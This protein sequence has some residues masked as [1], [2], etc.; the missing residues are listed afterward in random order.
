MEQALVCQAAC[1]SG[2]ECTEGELVRD[3]Q[4]QLDRVRFILWDL[5]YYALG[6]FAK[7]VFKLT[8]GKALQ[9]AVEGI[10]CAEQQG[11]FNSALERAAARVPAQRGA[12]NPLE[13]KAKKRKLDV[14]GGVK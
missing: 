1:N 14:G 10:T 6:T 11:R 4:L 2:G 8:G 3:T 9:Q 7:P 12:A 5:H 13:K